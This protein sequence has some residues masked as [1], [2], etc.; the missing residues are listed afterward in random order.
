MIKWYQ[1]AGALLSSHATEFSHHTH[2]HTT[3]TAHNFSTA[4]SLFLYTLFTVSL[5]NSILPKSVVA[6]AHHAHMKSS[7][8]KMSDNDIFT[9]RLAAWL[10][11]FSKPKHTHTLMW[12]R[13]AGEKRGFLPLICPRWRLKCELAAL[14]EQ[15]AWASARC[16][17]HQRYARLFI[18]KAVCVFALAHMHIIHLAA[19]AAAL[20]WWHTLSL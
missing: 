19:A 14:R 5:S 11:H 20:N 18:R 12:Y 1:Q 4:K 9:L 7:I 17:H 3:T 2:T 16:L 10:S 13:R 15:C 8:P 6:P